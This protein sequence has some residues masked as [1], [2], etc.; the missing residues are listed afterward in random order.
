M[1]RIIV[2]GKA[3]TFPFSLDG[4]EVVSAREYL[5]NPVYQARHDIR[6]FNLC[7]DVAYQSKGYYVSLL[8]EARG[9]RPVPNIR[10]VQDLKSSAAFS[11]AS[12][13]LQGSINTS[14]KSL[15][16]NEFTLSIY[17]GHN[18]AK[19]YDE[20]CRQI[21]RFFPIPLLQVKFI[22]RNTVWEI[23]SLSSIALSD[24]PSSHLPDVEIFATKYFA[25]RRYHGPKDPS[26]TYD[27]AILTN[28]EETSPPSNKRGLEK[29]RKA[30]EAEGFS[31]SF[32]TK[33]DYDRLNEFDALFIRETTAVHHHTYRMARRAQ[34]EGLAVIDSPEC[35]LRCAN[36]VYL[37][38]LLS[39]AKIPTPKTIVVH[40]DNKKTLAD[41]LPPPCVLKLPDS[42]FSLGVSKVNTKEEMAE[43]LE[44]LL[45]QSDLV[46]AQEYLPS[47][48]DWRIG[49]LDG[50]VLFACRYHMAKG[51]WQI[52]NWK[53][54][55]K[56]SREGKSDSVPLEDVPPDIIAMALK[57]TQL[58]GKGLFGVDLKEIDGKVYVIEVN[59]NPNVDAGSEDVL[60][61]DTVYRKIMRALRQR[62][63][64][65][66]PKE[67]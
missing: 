5:T 8:A 14:L 11:S 44:K 35:I 45:K 4:A 26:Q 17:F 30:A 21:L 48:F 18:L 42:S 65:S 56:S 49:V 47:A 38:E 51:H 16:S 33:N 3:K 13:E 53:K 39:N 1:R 41:I 19:R 10:T 46:I 54:E 20:L 2:T 25:L 27:L 36:K 24:I 6:V 50:E 29:F 37:A 12:K 7:A 31:V 66:L 23:Q 67:V 32:V 63:E 55:S 62:V 28:P 58:I 34:S 9:H 61:G 40:N 59:D 64:Q 57:S 60:L 43:S 15:K 52:Y 22:R